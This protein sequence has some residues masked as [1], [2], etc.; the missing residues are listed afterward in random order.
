M[1]QRS[2]IFYLEFLK[3][4][5]PLLWIW[6]EYPHILISVCLLPIIILLMYYFRPMEKRYK[7][8][9]YQQTAP[10]I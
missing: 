6:I 2:W 10:K 9:L 4:L 1:E 5:V 8:V 7:R 3:I